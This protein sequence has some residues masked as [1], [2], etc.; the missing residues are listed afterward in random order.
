VGQ[1]YLSYSGGFQE[2]QGMKL[3]SQAQLES[4]KEVLKKVDES[5]VGGFYSNFVK[6]LI[7]IVILR[8]HIIGNENGEGLGTS[9]S[10]FQILKL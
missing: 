10:N 2:Q 8:I 1:E 4:N 5:A 6:L 7:L 9:I 3:L